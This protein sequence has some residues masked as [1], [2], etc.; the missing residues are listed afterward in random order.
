MTHHDTG[1]GCVATLSGCSYM[2]IEIRQCMAMKNEKTKEACNFSKIINQSND[3]VRLLL[4]LS[5][6]LVQDEKKLK[7]LNETILNSFISRKHYDDTT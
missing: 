6:E 2:K 3:D 4:W 5:L 7:E 1:V